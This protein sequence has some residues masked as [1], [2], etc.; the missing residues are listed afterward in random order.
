MGLAGREAPPRR[1]S[2]KIS[3]F[4]LAAIA[5]VAFSTGAL[6]RSGEAAKLSDLPYAGL[7]GAL[8]LLAIMAVV[9]GAILTSRRLK[10]S[11]LFNRLFI[12]V[13]VT[14]GFFSGIR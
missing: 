2:G 6:A 3:A 7:A 12:V 5:S 14:S 4:A 9:L 11:S 1:K 13:A 10:G 8:S